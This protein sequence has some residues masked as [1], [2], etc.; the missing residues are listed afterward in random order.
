LNVVNNGPSLARRLKKA[1]SRVLLAGAGSALLAS[2]CAWDAPF[3]MFDGPKPPPP[4]TESL[5]LRTGGLEAETPPAE[6]TAEASLA[7]AKVHFRNAEYAK[8]E[9]LFRSIAD[10]KKNKPETAEEARFYEA[11]CNRMENH[12]PKAA[13]LYTKMLNDFPNGAFREQATQHLFEIADKWLDDT[14]EEIREAE[15]VREG[16]RWFTTPHFI[17][18]ERES[19]FLDQEG[20]A[21]EALDTVRIS[22]ILNTKAEGRLADKALFISGKV[23][24]FNNDYRAADDCFTQLVEQYPDSP[25]APQAVEMGIMCKQLGTGGARYDGRKVAEARVLVDKALRNYPELATGEK[26]ERMERQLIG[27]QLQQAEKDFEVAEFYRRS[28]HLPSAYFYYEIVRRRY[29]GTRFADQ[30]TERMHEIHDGAEKQQAGSTSVKV[31]GVPA[32]PVPTAQDQGVWGAPAPV[33]PPQST[34]PSAN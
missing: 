6:G 9:R 17:H 25:Y 16:K 24:L 18:F 22:D 23:K 12:L 10:E 28:D 3:H 1:W 15:E 30:A 32:A 20:R 29:P 14:R 2:G 5:I 34:P 19:P 7:G 31:P 13:D 4:P 11:E 26:R 27:I 8:A 33:Q 21:L